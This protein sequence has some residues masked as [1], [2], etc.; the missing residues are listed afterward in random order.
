M[1][2]RW[3]GVLGEVERVVV[4]ESMDVDGDGAFLLEPEVEDGIEIA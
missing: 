3:P 4:I 2:L 1:P